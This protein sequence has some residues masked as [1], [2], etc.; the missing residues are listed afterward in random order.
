MD[1]AWPYVLAVLVAGGLPLLAAVHWHGRWRRLQ[2]SV[3]AERLQSQ[4]VFDALDIGLLVFDAEDRVVQW[5]ADYLRL[6]PELAGEL[7]VGMRFEDILRAAV[8]RGGVPAAVG[9]EEAWIAERMAQHRQPREPLLRQMVD[10]RWRRI[11]ERYLADG[12]MVSY[13]IDVTALVTQGQA[14]EQARA[15]ADLARARLIEAIEVLPAGI[16]WFDA[17][18]RLVLANGHSRA[19]FPLVQDLMA[20][21]PTFE[22][23]VRANH[24]AGGLPNLQGDL[25]T[26]LARRLAQRSAGDTD[27]LIDVT[28]RWVRL[29]ERHTAE[30]GIINVRVDVSDEVAQRQAAETMR[31]QLQDAI[32]SL[33]DGFAYYDADDRLVL[34]NERYRTIYRESAPAIHPGA[35]FIDVLRYGLAHGQYPQAA[36]R[37]EAWLAERVQAHREPGPPVLQEL[38]GNRWLRIDERRTR[39]GGVAGVRADVTALV[40]REQTLAAL[41]R[42]L[43][44]AN[45]R[46][47]ELLGQDPDTGA[48]SAAALEQALTREWAR[49]RRHGTPL[50]LLRVHVEAAG[51]EADGDAPMQALA[52]HLAGCARRPGDLLARTA[53]RGFALLLPHTGTAALAALVQ[54]CS[55]GCR[56]V[57]A[58][59]TVHV[60]AAA[61]D[62]SPVPDSPDDLQARAVPG[63]SSAASNRA[64]A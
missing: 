33:P 49:S 64:A 17:D 37:E 35:A 25:D 18:D 28:G 23:L 2:R 48:A 43:D 8:Q 6:Y 10:G 52:R 4:Q 13:S 20:E 54:R 47:S 15:D 45:A 3:E 36:G 24:A 12:G 50:A 44:H 61:S 56:Q 55:E 60:G 59:W 51:G 38:P 11:T 62:E 57:A 22:Q 19:M 63:R 58:G 31:E 9:Q 21:Q 1:N 14:L 16:E 29:Y 41:N 46:L 5:N 42:Q 40:R 39:S 53:P 27:N 26:W 7:R 32:E 34:C 30:G